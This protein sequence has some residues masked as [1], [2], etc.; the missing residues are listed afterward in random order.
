MG[1]WGFALGAVFGVVVTIAAMAA[2]MGFAK[3]KG[4]SK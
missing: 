2:G 3:S 4:E 1:E